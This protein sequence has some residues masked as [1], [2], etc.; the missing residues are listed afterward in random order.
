MDFNKTLMTLHN[1]HWIQDGITWTT[2]DFPPKK[3][4]NLEL[5]G[6]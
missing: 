6:F 4:L 5:H 2:S 1:K 3:R